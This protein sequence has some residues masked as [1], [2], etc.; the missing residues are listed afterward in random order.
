MAAIELLL[1]EGLGR[2]PQAEEAPAPRLP[3]TV[4]AI[5]RLGWTEMKLVFA[6]V[7]AGEITAVSAGG[8]ALLRERVVALDEDQRRMLRKALDEV[9]IA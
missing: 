6:T 4:E 2:P 7:F 1:R 9:A 3:A 5:E 8:D